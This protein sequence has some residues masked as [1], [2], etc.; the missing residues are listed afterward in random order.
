MVK[1]V[2]QMLEQTTEKLPERIAFSD[3]KGALSYIEVVNLSK[4]VGSRLIQM[5]KQHQPVAIMLEKS[6]EMLIGFFG[7][8]YSG[9]FYI[10]IDVDMPSDRIAKIFSS[11][12]PMAIITDDTY[13]KKTSEIVNTYKIDCEIIRY[14]EAKKTIQDEKALI[15]IRN[16]GIDTDPVYALF[17]SGSTGMPKGVIC[18]HRSVIDY[19]DWLIETFPINRDTVFGNQ[20]PFYFSMSVLDIYATIRSGAELHI[21]PKKMFAFPAALLEH[22][23]ITRVNTIYW[24]PTALCLVAN[25][26]VLDKI[27]LPY[28][29]TVLFAGETMPTK[30]LNIWRKYLPNALF[31]NLFG[32]TEITDIGVYY[33]VDR[34]FSDDE[35]LPIG[36][37]CD[38]VDA[39]ILNLDGTNIVNNGEIGELCIRGSYLAMGY[40]DNPQKTNESFTQNPLNHHYPEVIY[41]TGDL[42]SINEFGEMIYH[43]RKDFQI[44]HKGNRIELGEIENAAAAV[45]GIEMC[46]CIYDTAKERIVLFFQGDNVD[47]RIIRNTLKQKIPVYMIPNLMIK[48]ES[49][50][51]NANGKIDRTI[52]KDR[53]IDS[54]GEI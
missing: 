54:Q 11:V 13:M 6:K 25:T 45:Q 19:A 38:N 21:I 17:T 47:N 20:T 18:C 44:K 50:P 2:L 48:L 23:N 10:P 16:K 4:A 27:E 14:E 3:E 35:P 22:M 42:V 1:N 43:G 36:K 37:E 7:V 40:Y 30:Q 5:K 41:H 9:N 51:K 46:A 31:A 28:L 8:I 52:L 53:L 29:K 34:E 33:I 12:N 39:M 24:V 15:N 26:R 49:M 32:P